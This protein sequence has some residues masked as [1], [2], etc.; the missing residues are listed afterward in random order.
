M[1]SD[2]VLALIHTD[3]LHHQINLDKCYQESCNVHKT[4]K[5]AVMT[6]SDVA[7][8]TQ[9]NAFCLCANDSSPDDFLLSLHIHKKH[10]K[11][12]CVTISDICQQWGEM[13]V[14][15]KRY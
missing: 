15:R 9:N 1:E 10:S 11:K 8:N 4:V 3:S 5:V 12:T 6:S 14:S 7:E 2:N 13:K